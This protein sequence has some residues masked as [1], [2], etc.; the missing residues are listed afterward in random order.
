MP[1]I[2]KGKCVFNEELKQKFPF[3]KKTYN[4]YNVRC[5]KCSVI[6][7]IANG[8]QYDIKRHLNTNKH[9]SAFCAANETKS[10]SNY[11]SPRDAPDLSVCAKEGVWAYH[12]VA[13]NHSFR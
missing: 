12:T 6:F 2:T 10:L 8:G 7:S 13:E 9:K 4:D 5:E 3:I 11:F 1:K